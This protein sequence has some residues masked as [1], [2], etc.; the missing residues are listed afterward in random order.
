MGP[1]RRKTDLEGPAP[2][3]DHEYIMQI[4]CATRTI[5]SKLDEVCRRQE[6]SNGRLAVVEEWQERAN[7][8]LLMAAKSLAIL[9]ALVALFGLVIKIAGG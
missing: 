3:N 5:D 9:V 4:Y 6:V 8:A 1:N 7:G 2:E